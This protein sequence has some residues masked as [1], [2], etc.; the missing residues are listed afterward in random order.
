MMTARFTR[1]LP[2]LPR[3]SRFAP[4]TGFGPVRRTLPVLALLVATLLGCSRG[5]PDSAAQVAEPQFF[6]VYKV[7]IPLTGRLEA[8]DSAVYSSSIPHK[9]MKITWLVDEG[10]YVNPG[11]RLIRFDDSELRE[12]R[13][14]LERKRDETMRERDKAIEDFKMERLAFEEALQQARFDRRR[15]TKKLETFVKFSGPSQL[16]QLE[17]EG[18]LATLKVQRLERETKDIELLHE[19][20][21]VT[22]FEL[23]THRENL[24]K[25]RYDREK[26]EYQ[27]QTYQKHGMN[28]ERV[29]LESE[30]QLIATKVSQ[31]EERFVL[32]NE[33][34][35]QKLKRFDQRLA[36]QER[37]LE[38]L[39]SYLADCTLAADHAGLVIYRKSYRDGQDV[40]PSVGFEYRRA[41]PILHI[42]NTERLYVS[43]RV[44]EF[45]L[46]K[47]EVGMPVL[48]VA[49]ARQD[50]SFDGRISFIG[51]LAERKN[52]DA[53]KAFDMSIEALEPPSGLRPGMSVRC[54]II[55]GSYE[56]I[57]TVPRESLAPMR[58]RMACR[59]LRDGK[60]MWLDVDVLDYDQQTAILQ[61]EFAPRDRVLLN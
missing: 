9:S 59:V 26:A 45:L 29:A 46:N 20:G 30:D 55:S 15:S 14:T 18:H 12:E 28:D 27:Y 47:V 39:E 34:H 11:D 32:L 48:L 22:G 24:L 37:E 33:Q 53:E 35:G 60:Q 5:T 10:V 43:A 31:L 3:S 38:D 2:Y 17:Q 56:K 6:P 19:K 51:L 54:E 16:K 58:E 21:Y 7:R 42:Q 40:K 13:R 23:E 4:S 8:A 52:H 49:D 25:A 50:Q 41:Q 57:W 44:N 1:Y 36:Q 61:A